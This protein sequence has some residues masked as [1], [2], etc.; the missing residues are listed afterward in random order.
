MQRAIK[1]AVPLSRTANKNPKSLYIIR[2]N[3]STVNRNIDVI[4]AILTLVSVTI[5]IWGSGLL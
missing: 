1:K 5:L 4:C 2:I 3:K